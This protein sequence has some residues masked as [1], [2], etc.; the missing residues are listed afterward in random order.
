MRDE[1][2]ARLPAQARFALMGIVDEIGALAD[3]IDGLERATVVQ[4]N[5]DGDMRR[6]TTISGVGAIAAAIIK[7]LVP[8]AAG[9]SRLVT[10]PRA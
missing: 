5:R 9:S 4:A 3:Q 7:A 2:E 1:T 8:D 10:L 6:L